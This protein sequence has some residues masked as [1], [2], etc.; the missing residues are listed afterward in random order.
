MTKFV[1]QVKLGLFKVFPDLQDH[2][3]QVQGHRQPG[4]SKELGL[5][6]QGKAPRAWFLGK[7][8]GTKVVQHVFKVF[9][10]IYGYLG[11]VQR[12]NTARSTPRDLDKYVEI[13][14]VLDYEKG[15][16]LKFCDKLQQAWTTFKLLEPLQMLAK[17][18]AHSAQY[19][20]CCMEGLIFRNFK[21]LC[22]WST[23]E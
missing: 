11:Q 23:D 10:D 9:L 1:Q 20:P 16:S 18:A 12:Q 21:A 6:E 14:V 13:K 7:V 19:R 3:G 4:V 2:L 15:L 17:Q 5:I 8:A 22:H